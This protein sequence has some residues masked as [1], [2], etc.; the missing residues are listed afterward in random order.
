MPA[1]LVARA[2]VFAAAVSCLGAAAQSTL[3]RWVDK[4]GKVHFTDTPPPADAKGATQKRYGSAPDDQ[5]LP[6]ATQ[7]AMRRNPVMLWVVPD[8]EPCARGRELLANRGI[9]FS[10]R[11]AQSNVPTQEALKKLQGDLNVP[12]LEIG[13]NR[14]KGYE[15]GSWHSALD[16]AGYP[17]ERPYGMP[18]TKPTIAN[19]PAAPKAATPEAAAK[20]Q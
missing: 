20:T 3:Y 1:S 15:E 16:T 17:R 6:F 18:P 9:P 12:V 7:E 4:D 5:P 13:S 19:L 14:I 2:L 8:C 10:E 11:D